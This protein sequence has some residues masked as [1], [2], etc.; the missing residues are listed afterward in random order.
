MKKRFHDGAHRGAHC[1]CAVHNKWHL[2]GTP[3]P[4][5]VGEQ[6]SESSTGRK[7][8][9]AG[10]LRLR[11][12]LPRAQR[13]ASDTVPGLCRDKQIDA[14]STAGYGV[15]QQKKLKLYKSIKKA[16]ENFIEIIKCLKNKTKKAAC[17]KQDCLARNVGDHAK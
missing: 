6:F 3:Q 5:T 14:P 7:R 4:P 11:S 10:V 1:G 17:Y 13:V 16:P 8:H 12:H 2:Q 15:E 9:G